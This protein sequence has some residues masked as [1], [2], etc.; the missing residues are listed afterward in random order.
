MVVGDHEINYNN[1]DSDSRN[2]I[3]E[4][5][6]GSHRRDVT[7]GRLL[8]TTM[9]KPA[10]TVSTLL[11]FTGTGIWGH[12]FEHVSAFVPDGQDAS[13]R[14]KLYVKLSLDNID[15]IIPGLHGYWSH[16]VQCWRYDY[17]PDNVTQPHQSY[18]TWMA[19]QRV[20]A[21]T[22]EQQHL[23]YRSYLHQRATAAL[24]GSTCLLVEQ[25]QPPQACLGMRIRQ[26]DKAA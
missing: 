2:D 24:G 4:R 5:I 6:Q 1:S 8:T 23:H 25:Q 12:Y 17:L 16:T 11:Q 21:A 9:N 7:P 18:H 19:P 13:C 26:A 10:T 20:R 15:L 3:V 22:I 14:D